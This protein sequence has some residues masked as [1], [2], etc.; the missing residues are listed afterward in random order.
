M[1]TYT[2]PLIKLGVGH[3]SFRRAWP[4]SITAIDA[5]CRDARPA[6]LMR[7]ARAQAC[8]SAL[9]VRPPRLV[10]GAVMLRN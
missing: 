9:S 5:D 3:P 4:D 2:P 10:P 6:A 1:D 7:T 8:R